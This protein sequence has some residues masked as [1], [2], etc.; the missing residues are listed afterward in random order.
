M[1]LD[2]R[3]SLVASIICLL[4]SVCFVSSSNAESGDD[5]YES[6]VVYRNNGQIDEA[7]AEFRKAIESF[8]EV[9]RDL[10]AGVKKKLDVH[11]NLANAYNDLGEILLEEGKNGEALEELRK[12][13]E[14][15]RKIIEKLQKVAK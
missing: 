5:H 2:S 1:V 8:A 3:W 13:G 4:V 7:K 14:E 12:A 11:P 10:F 9:G 6:G 15:Y